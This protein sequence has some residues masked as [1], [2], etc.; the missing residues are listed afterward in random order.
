LRKGFFIFFVVLLLLI[1]LFTYL[2]Y[3][4][5][6]TSML[7][8]LVRGD[9]LKKADLI[10]A[11]GGENFRKTEAKRL[12]REGYAKKILFTGFEIEKDDYKRYGLKEGEFIYP[13]K[14]VFNTYEE[15]VFVKEVVKKHNFKSVIIVTAF[16]HSRRASY[17][18]KKLLEKEGVEVIVVPVFHKNFEINEWW[19]NRYLLKVVFI[20][21]LGLLYYQLEY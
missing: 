6:L 11:L 15:A 12:F 2:F 17:I 8:N 1:S 18:F 5:V 3:E 9:A 16:Y 14:Y 10:V 7:T 20:E 21:W 4:Q 13:V 19:K